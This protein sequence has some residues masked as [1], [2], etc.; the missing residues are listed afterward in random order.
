MTLSEKILELCSWFKII[1][2]RL[3]VAIREIN[4]E[5]RLARLQV[6]FSLLGGIFG[7]AYAIF[8]SA[9]GHTAGSIVVISC[10]VSMVLTIPVLMMSS[11]T[12]LVGNIQSGVLIFG[13]AVLAAIEGGARGHALAW[14]A[15][16]PLCAL[17][18]ARRPGAYVW[19]IIAIALTSVFA[20]LEWMGIAV[21]I[22]Y[23]D[24][25]HYPVNALGYLGLP[26]FLCGLGATFEGTRAIAVREKDEALHSLATA[27][28]R[29]VVLNAEKDEFLQIAAHDLKNPLTTMQG[30]SEM[31][32]EGIITQAD[33]VQATGKTLFAMS[34]RMTNIVTE[35]LDINAIEQ[36]KY[37]VKLEVI[38]IAPV[39]TEAVERLTLAA[40]KKSIQI[41]FHTPSVMAIADAKALGQ[42]L[43]NLLSNALKY[44]NPGTTVEMRTA[45]SDE[46]AVVEVVD[47]GLGLSEEDQK[48]LFQKFTRLSSRPTAGE[49]S[50]GLG[51]SIVKRIA[52]SMG[53]NV[54]CQSQLGIGS[55]FQV[56]LPL[57][58]AAE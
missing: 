10:T 30:Y 44:S 21:P 25:W 51:L 48:K 17:L 47:E 36:G 57:A 45:A 54:Y 8:Y 43:D 38:D 53:G 23:P 29:L 2:R 14:L 46:H 27:N 40:E 9:I 6:G 56:M 37:P 20:I 3:P 22:L 12:R 4:D 42:I 49:S 26:I 28:K 1:D 7:S 50:T 35:L 52:E 55:T 33:K 41:V 58:A 19:C 34:R 32:G 16:S 13:F 5:R 15:T 11:N 31:L 18:L 39:A 24:R